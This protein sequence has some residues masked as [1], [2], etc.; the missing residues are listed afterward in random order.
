MTSTLIATANPLQ[1]LQTYGQSVWL[2]YIR[3]NLITSGELQRMVDAGEIWGVTS[4]P[5]IFQKAIAGSTDYDEALKTLEQKHDRNPMALYEAFAI[6]DIQATADIL[7]PVYEKTNKRDGYVSLEVSPYLAHNTEET[8]TEAHRLWLAVD[9]PN[10]MIKVPATPAGIPA[11]QQLIG[12]GININVTLLF[13]KAVYEQVANAYIAGLEALVAKG[14][15]VSHVASVASFFVSRIDTAID[16]QI[17]AQLKVMTHKETRQLLQTIQGKIAI[18]NAKVTYQR[19]QELYRSDRWQALAAQGAQTQRLLWASTG[20]KNPHYS[21]VLYVEELVGADTVNTIPPA[22]LAAFR[23]HGHPRSSLRQDLD[24]A[25][26]TMQNLQQANISLE[27]VTDQLLTEGVQLFRDAFDQLLSVVEQQ[28]EARLG[29]KLDQL[30]YKLPEGLNT[31][32]QASLQDWQVN[33]KI[34]RLW[35]QDATLWTGADENRWLGWLGITEDQLAHLERLKLL[36]AEVQDLKFS[37]VVLLGMGG[38]SLCPIVMKATFGKVEGYPELLVLDS[39]DP[40]QIKT[41]ENQ[42]NLTT[43]LFIVSSK[44]GSTLE[45]NIFKQYFFDRVQQILGAESAGNRFIAITDPDSKLQHI[46]AGD[47]FRHIFAGVSSIGGRYSALSNFGMVPAAAMG[48][49]V[50]KFLNHA[51]EMVHSCAPSVPAKDNPGVVLG[52]ILGQAANQGQDKV[53]F[54]SSPGVESLG[55]WLEQLLAESTGKDGK[56]IIP[57]DWEPIGSPTVYGNDRLFVYIR[58]ESAPEATQDAAVA[59][60]EQAGHP[61]VRIAIADPYQLGQEFFRWEIAT[62]VAGSIIGI[63]AFNQPDVEASKIATRQ[64]TTEYEKTGLLP[65]ETPIAIEAGIQLYTD[66]KNAAALAQAARSDRSLGGYL[67]AHLAHLQPGDYFALLAYIEMNSQHATQLQEIRQS[68]RDAKQVATCLGFGPRFLH[69]TGQA[70]KG[71]P[72]TGVFLQITCDDA[73][74]LAVLGQEYSFG[75]VKAAQARGD[76]QV[77]A[78]RDRRALRVHLADVE[79]GLATLKHLIQQSLV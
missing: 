17:A 1:A 51:E 20:T 62:A 11:I 4:N 55:A 34:R 66:P 25:Q 75:V 35:A 72:N 58:L 23:D 31:A 24:A 64:L 7:R 26:E 60:L 46:A 10:L 29:N 2:D 38:S 6:E 39:T 43:T 16:N 50:A 76:F 40:A 79:A 49:D 68:I 48:V 12:D 77:L 19:Y 37:H 5:A 65:A 47:D 53:T 54:I 74:D 57:I 3:R 30:T 73:I 41:L 14:G 61:V 27:R 28:R 44:S 9:R 32:V 22:T 42:I 63:H 8:I 18:A 33:G 45:P 78:E 67:R 21:D 70:Y 13:S 59:A 15:T 69:S 56:G 52:T 36:A 71:G